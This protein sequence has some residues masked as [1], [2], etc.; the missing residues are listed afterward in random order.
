MWEWLFCAGILGCI[1]AYFKWAWNQP[2]KP[3]VAERKAAE[4]R[5]Q[6]GDYSEKDMQ[7]VVSH[8]IKEREIGPCKDECL[9]SWRD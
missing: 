4:Q 8:L 7:L 9:F 5:I 1:A 2:D 3:E 6:N